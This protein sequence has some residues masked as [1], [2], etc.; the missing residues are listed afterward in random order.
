MKNIL[1]VPAPEWRDALLGQSV[2]GGRP[3][4][5]TASFTP[6]KGPVEAGPGIHVTEEWTCPYC[7][8]D[9]VSAWKTIKAAEERIRH[10]HTCP[11]WGLVLA[12]D[13]KMAS[14]GHH[15]AVRTLLFREGVTLHDLGACWRSTGDEDLPTQL[16]QMLKVVSPPRI[17]VRW[18]LSSPGFEFDYVGCNPEDDQ[19]CVSELLSAPDGDLRAPWALGTVCTARGLG[20]L[21]VS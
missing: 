5:F 7:Y 19:F 14:D 10:F 18:T 8:G 12:W 1:L 3:P 21:E 4:K 17:D 9:A 15:R 11:L 20:R 6:V 13:G 2:C 16:R